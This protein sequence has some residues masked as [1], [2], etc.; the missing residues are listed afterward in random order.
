MKIAG[1]GTTAL[2]AGGWSEWCSNPQRPVVTQ[3]A[4]D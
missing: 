3:G 2:Y 4:Q 1:L